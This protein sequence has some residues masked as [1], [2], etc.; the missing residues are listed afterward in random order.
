MV[1]EKKPEYWRWLETNWV[2]PDI[3]WQDTKIITCGIDVGSVSSQ[4]VI[5]ADGKICV[6]QHED[7]FGQPQQ[8]KGSP[9]VRI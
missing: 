3:K 7:G 5:M 9:Q 8:R 4:A 1:E 6:W 2:N